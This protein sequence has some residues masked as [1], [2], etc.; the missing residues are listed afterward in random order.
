MLKVAPFSEMGK[1]S[2][3]HLEVQSPELCLRHVGFEMPLR[4]S[5]GDV[6]CKFGVRGVWS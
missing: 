2:K 4:H 6:K 3:E 5:N 1:T